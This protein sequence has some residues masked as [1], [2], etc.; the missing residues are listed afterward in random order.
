MNTAVNAGIIAVM[1]TARAEL[2][3]RRGLGRSCARGPR[4][5]SRCVL[6]FVFF[7]HEYHCDTQLWTRAAH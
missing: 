1:W 2:P 3:G 5:E 4:F 7:A 6:K